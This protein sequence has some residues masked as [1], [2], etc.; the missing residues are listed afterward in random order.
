MNL[1]LN[2]KHLE[3]F[4]K[5]AQTGSINKAAQALY[6]SQPYLGKIITELENSLGTVLM[7][8][9]RS[10]V[11]LTDDGSR[12][13]VRAE[14]VVREA[15]KLR[16]TFSKAPASQT[17]LIV[18]STKWSHIMDSFIEVVQAHEQEPS[19]S[20]QLK[21]GSTEEVIDDMFSGQ[22]NV[23]IIH[24][25]SRRS[26]EIRASLASKGLTYHFLAFIRPH[27][28]ISGRHPLIQAGEKVCPENLAGY[29]LAR[30]TGQYEDFS[31]QIT[32]GSTTYNLNAGPRI[33]YLSDRASLLHLI[34]ESDFYSI[35][36]HDFSGQR[37]LYDVVSIPVEDCSSMLEFG[38]LLPENAAVSAITGDFLEAVSKRLRSL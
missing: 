9:T 12:F 25:D 24:F 14:A 29:G 5:V 31:Y 22:A 16:E 17:P 8:R 26:G 33:V 36:I 7:Q 19:F 28:I 18:S 13:L 6:I 10:G 32:C 23:G 21:E 20:H 38:Y 15:R 30:Y 34:S 2:L 4:L 37:S 27:I 35:G 3:Y 1:D 11:I